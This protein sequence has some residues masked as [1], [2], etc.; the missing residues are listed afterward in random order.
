MAFFSMANLFHR[1]Y[2]EMM[3]PAIAALVGAGVVAMWDDYRRP[4]WRGWLLPLALVVTAAVEAVILAPFPDWSR[5]LTP[6]VVGLCMVLAGVLA[7][8]RNRA[9]SSTNGYAI[10][11]TQYAITIGVLALLIAPTVWATIPVWYGGDVALP[12]AGPELLEKPSRR[13]DLP[14]VSR[15]VDYLLTNRGGEPFLVATIRA[16]E[17][18]PIILATGEPVMALGGF[19]G[20]DRILSVDD[21]EEW[22]AAGTVRFFLLS[23]QGGRQQDL[24]RWITSHCRPV[25]SEEWRPAAPGPR[26]PH[27][28]RP[29]GMS[30]L[31][32]CQKG[33]A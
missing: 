18:A 28:Y 7:F 11:G 12:F 26:P 16:N 9:L 15:L 2:L 19:S 31:F 17:A 5:W 25:P 22:V 27:N 33:S 14:D 13:G 21:L 4:G 20:G 10:R 30:Q 8:L 32:N 24:I 1:Y 6:L 23:P 3:A 29:S